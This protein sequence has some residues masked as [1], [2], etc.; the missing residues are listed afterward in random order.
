MI[1]L[2]K[3][4]FVVEVIRKHWF[5]PLVHTISISFLFIIPIVGIF[6]LLGVSIPTGID[7]SFTLS[8]SFL[9]ANTSYIFFGIS[10]W[11]LFLW[12]RFF[13]FWTDYHLDGWIITNKR[14]VDIEQRGF[15]RRNIASFR[16]ERLQDVNTV[17]NGIIAT[18]LNFGDIHVQTAGSE[19]EFVLKYAQNPGHVK[20][21]IMNQHDEI[22]ESRDFERN[23][24]DVGDSS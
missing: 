14:V 11:G 4:E 24:D 15:F 13:T 2:A 22:L 21:V 12:L 18:F 6:L 7:R 23:L 19:R 10:F 20:Q 1:K 3:D 9:F 5:P 17:V 8:L 16:L